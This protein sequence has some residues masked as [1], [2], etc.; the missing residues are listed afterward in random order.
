MEDPNKEAKEKFEI[1]NE[2]EAK[3]VVENLKK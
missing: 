2:E 1:K 3:E